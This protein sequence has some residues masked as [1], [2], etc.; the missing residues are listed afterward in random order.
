MAENHV[1]KKPKPITSPLFMMESQGLTISLLMSLKA[2][3]AHGMAP[4][5]FTIPSGKTD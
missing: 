1:L 5:D 3:A 2:N 4:E